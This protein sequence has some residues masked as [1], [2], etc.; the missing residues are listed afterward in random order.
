MTE[1]QS[2]QQDQQQEEEIQPKFIPNSTHSIAIHNILHNAQQ[3]HGGGGITNKN[4]NNSLSIQDYTDYTQYRN[5]LTRRL[6]RIR[7]AKPVMKTLSHGPKSKRDGPSTTNNTTTANSANTGGGGGGTKQRKGGKHSF[8]P[9]DPITTQHTS[10]HPNY[11]LDIIYTIER[12]W[13][14]GL[15]LK[16][17]YQHY[18]STN[19]NNNRHH[20]SNNS[21]NNRNI[22]FKKN[23]TSPGKV[24]QHYLNKM[25]KAFRN[26]QHLEDCVI[27]EEGSVCDDR[28]CHEVKC[29]IAWMRG[30]YYCEI[31]NWK[32]RKHHVHL[33]I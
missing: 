18:I 33:L 1:E 10:L 5:Y 14:H 23:H 8:N 7:H 16:S 27:V 26:V 12:D 30:N 4:G 2:L 15:E 25:K 24:R 17:F 31:Q 22:S 20:H 32:V 21:N 9:R 3:S 13:V 11:I 29:Y 28:T 19:N 6:S